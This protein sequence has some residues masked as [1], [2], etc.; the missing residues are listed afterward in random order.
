MMVL[1][2]L[3][4]LVGGALIFLGCI[5]VFAELDD[6]FAGRREDPGPVFGFGL[7]A[8]FLAGGATLA[9]RGRGQGRR[10]HGS[11]DIDP[12]LTSMPFDAP[13]PSLP[14][15]RKGTVLLLGAPA[16]F[17]RDGGDCAP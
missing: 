8:V 12:D 2:C 17:N 6:L 14:A 1:R 5:G 11:P 15:R 13:T 16:R 10:A 4:R 7:A 3:R 9:R